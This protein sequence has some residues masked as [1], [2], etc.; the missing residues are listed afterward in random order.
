MSKSQQMVHGD[1][2]Y[3]DAGAITIP[4]KPTWIATVAASGIVVTVYDSIRKLGGVTHYTHPIR[5][6]GLSSPR[7][8]A[9]AI[10]GLVRKLEAK[11]CKKESME[12]HFYG[13][14]DNNIAPR[15]KSGFSQKNVEVGEEVLK[16]LNMSINCRD[17]GGRRARKIMFNSTTGETV[18][19]K[20]NKVRSEDWY[21]LI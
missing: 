4:E 10:V 20:V 1:C 2:C 21:P 12:V 16:K 17:I 14:A 11:G 19:A 15:Y 6:K 8:A 5:Q 18:V 13:A 7:F 3:M 9:P